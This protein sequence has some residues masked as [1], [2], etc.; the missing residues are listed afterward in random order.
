MISTYCLVIEGS[1]PRSVDDMLSDRFQ[2]LRIWT[3]ADRAV[4]DCPVSD[5]PAL[6]A[7]VT[8]V[9]DLGARVLLLADV[10]GE[11]GARR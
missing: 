5:Q 6:R 9:W 8:Q 4:I 11:R 10:S 7:L 1:L 2:G 3:S